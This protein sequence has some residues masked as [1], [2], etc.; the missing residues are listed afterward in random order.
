MT[1]MAAEAGWDHANVSKPQAIRTRLARSISI[2]RG[3]VGT[4]SCPP[5]WRPP[6]RSTGV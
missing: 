3:R 4:M 1:V 6:Q 5:D 2:C